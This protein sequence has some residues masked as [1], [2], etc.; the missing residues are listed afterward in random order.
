M[1]TL[2][3]NQA[4]LNTLAKLSIWAW[5]ETDEPNI[6]IFK[7]CYIVYITLCCILCKKKKQPDGLRVNKKKKSMY[8]TNNNNDYNTKSV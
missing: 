7:I 4:K 1:Q 2:T 8:L 5:S 6:W 3:K